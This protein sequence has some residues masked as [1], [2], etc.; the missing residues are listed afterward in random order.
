MTYNRLRCLGGEITFGD[1]VA[2]KLLGS[3]GGDRAGGTESLQPVRLSRRGTV[4]KQF[5]DSIQANVSLTRIH[6][7]ERWECKTSNHR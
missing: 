7:E 4:Q 3:G 5:V 6:Y 2:S 1:E